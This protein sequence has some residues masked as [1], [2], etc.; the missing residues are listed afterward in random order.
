MG[1]I[2]MDE[3]GDTGLRGGS[4]FFVLGA[5]AFFDLQVAQQCQEAI[6]K[7]RLQLGV[8]KT[9]E[10]HFSR[11]R[12]EHAERFLLTVAEYPFR[13]YLC[14]IDKS[15]LRG[16]AWRK[17]LYMYEQAAYIALRE[18]LPE[19]CDAKLVF[20]RKSQSKTF[21]RDFLA[22][23]RRHAGYREGMPVISETQ[24]MK[25]HSYDLLQVADMVI[26]AAISESDD[27]RS[28]VKK[29]EGS[30]ELFP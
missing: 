30:F 5:V 28:I 21:E 25:S 20:D 23:V 29:S 1:L 3:S 12:R 4:P 19:I 26:G 24:S 11:C 7:L 10:F 18:L 16:K 9:E 15:K 22:R 8:K 13:Y 14:R 27:L 2:L 6:A 17:R